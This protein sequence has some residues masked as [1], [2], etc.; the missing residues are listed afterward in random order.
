MVTDGNADC[1]ILKQK[2][3]TN[4]HIREEFSLNNCMSTDF[5]NVAVLNKILSI[6]PTV[7]SV[8]YTN[9]GHV[10]ITWKTVGVAGK[11]FLFVLSVFLPERT[12]F[13]IFL[14]FFSI[15]GAYNV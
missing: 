10:H 8:E 5:S 4:N 15:F 13:P 1:T 9:F 11:E 6:I 7:N 12:V 3:S 2:L 14:L